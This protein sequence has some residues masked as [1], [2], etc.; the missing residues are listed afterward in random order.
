MKIIYVTGCLG[1]IPSYFTKK[2]LE[3]GWKV[4][5]VDKAT[6]AAN[7]GLLDEFNKYD[8]FKFEKIDIKDMT[9]LYDCDY[10]VNFAAESHVGNSIINSDEFISTNI[11]GTQ[12]LLELI[13]NKPVNCVE[14]PIFLHISTDEVYGDIKSG[15]HFETDL[16][17]PSNPYSAAKAAADML[18]L[19]WSRTYGIKHMIAR[20]TNNYGA[21]Q[22]PEKLI[23]ITIKNLQRNKKIRLHDG[24]E[25][26]RNWLHADDTAEAIMTLIEKGEPNEIYNISGDFEQ[27]NK[28][29][30]RKIITHFY[31]NET[32]WE[33]FVDYSFMRQG[34]DVRYSLND[35]KIRNL[36]WKPKKIF[37][38][39]IKNIVDWHKENFR[40]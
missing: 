14:S 16:L 31:D 22:Y 25:P 37:D 24:G 26:T 18:V 10:V 30:V 29:T 28:D 21:G 15:E 39:E 1:F 36:G 34:Q 11:L 6:Y 23:P 4:F 35:D 33:N 38:E 40:W 27:K 3:K 17:H 8:N 7:E 9:M 20:P 2:A 12:N 13:R 19:A 32:E 5:G